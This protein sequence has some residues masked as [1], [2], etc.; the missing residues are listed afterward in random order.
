MLKKLGL[1]DCF[2]G[3]IC[4][5][6]LNPPSSSYGVEEE[7]SEIFDII[8]H[9]SKPNSALDLPKSPILCKPSVEA[10]EHALRIANI[11]PQ[12]TVFFDDSVRNI[13]SGKHIGLQTVLIGT[14]HRVKGADHA[15]ESIHNIKEALP[16][17]WEED[18][19]SDNM[20]HSDKVAIETYVTA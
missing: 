17:L 2:E 1:A 11:D 20:R 13:Q 15:L 8:D 6:T 5:E 4:F 16:E 10:M 12:R 3:I 18:E 19:E 7:S 14:P 9:L